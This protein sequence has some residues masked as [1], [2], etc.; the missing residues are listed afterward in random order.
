M[1]GAATPPVLRPA[2]P[3]YAPEVLALPRSWFIGSSRL[4]DSDSDG[5][6]DRAS[7]A[8]ALS[9]ELAFIGVMRTRLH[10]LGRSGWHTTTALRYV[11]DELDA[12][13]IAVKLHL[14]SEK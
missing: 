14:E 8:E 13:E 12:Y 3:R 4:S 2:R 1:R 7:A 11:L 10:E 6:G 5:D 9:L